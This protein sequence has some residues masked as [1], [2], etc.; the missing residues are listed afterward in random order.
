MAKR[1]LTI[2]GCSPA[3]YAPQQHEQQVQATGQA[4]MTG[5]EDAAWEPVATGLA[6][7]PLNP[8]LLLTLST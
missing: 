3:F 2:L 8:F 1:A 6:V 4:N 5:E 7:A